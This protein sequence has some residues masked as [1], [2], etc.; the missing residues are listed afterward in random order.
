MSPSRYDVFLHLDLLESVPKRGDARRQIMQF[1]ASLRDHPRTPGDFTNKDSSMRIREV[2]I[3]ADYA[4]TYWLDD[5]VKAV[6][7]VD[8][9]LADR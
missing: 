1:I 5:P 8:I 7:I 9:Q 3:I 4:I 2:R 6:M